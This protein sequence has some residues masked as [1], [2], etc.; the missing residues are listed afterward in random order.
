MDRDRS[1]V[2]TE[3][4]IHSL[5]EGEEDRQESGS[6]RG[7]DSGGKDG[8]RS[9]GSKAGEGMSTVKFPLGKEGGNQ[10]EWTE[11]GIG[12]PS[13]SSL[14]GGVSDETVSSSTTIRE[15]TVTSSNLG[16]AHL[17]PS[18]YDDQAHHVTQQQRIMTA[19]PRF[20]VNSMN[21]V[22]PASKK[23]A[24]EG[25]S[26]AE[27]GGRMMI[28][29]GS[30]L[31][32]G[33]DESFTK[34]GVGIPLGHSNMRTT[35]K[36]PPGKMRMRIR[37]VDPTIHPRLGSRLGNVTGGS[38]SSGYS[39]PAVPSSPVKAGS[40]EMILSPPGSPRKFRVRR[41]SGFGSSASG[42]EI[43]ESE[44]ERRR[45]R[46]RRDKACK[47][48]KEMGESEERFRSG[49]NVVIDVSKLKW[50]CRLKA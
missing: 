15:M 26:E 45:L 41:A 9:G 6:L 13:G 27:G 10:L 12:K 14:S 40:V 24:V 31:L 49:L 21:A 34:T 30:G 23:W 47:T 25:G 1:S 4:S 2:Y 46:D 18:L 32:V 35:S 16:R 29:P 5:P 28:G 38:S 8:E 7:S 11:T 42:R 20:R 19:Y 36:P 43:V 44:A 17:R 39:T 33:M 22:L 37:S 3:R 48:V 50:R